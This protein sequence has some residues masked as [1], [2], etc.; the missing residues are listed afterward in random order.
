MAA[1]S[2]PVAGAARAPFG[3]WRMP[4]AAV[5]V[6]AVCLAAV[7][8][9]IAGEHHQPGITVLR[10]V[11]YVGLDEAS[12]TVGGWTYGIDGASNVTWVDDQGSEHT[13]GWP[14]CLRPG[15]IVPITFGEIPWTAP[16][17]S[18]LRQVVWVDCKPPTR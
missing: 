18:G 10:G 8:G 5:V 3:I 6:L 4:W 12:V 7:L 9:F 13:S 17:G 2:M 14:S 16:D 15:N 1:S 11:A